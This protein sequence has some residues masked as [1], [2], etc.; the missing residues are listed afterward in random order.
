MLVPRTRL[1]ISDACA[2]GSPKDYFP[3][4]VQFTAQSAVKLSGQIDKRKME[5]GLFAHGVALFP[6]IGRLVYLWLACSWA[7]ASIRIVFVV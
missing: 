6:T 1:S 3:R 5:L 7:M 4:P 2:Y